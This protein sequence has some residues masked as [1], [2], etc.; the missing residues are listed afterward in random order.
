MNFDPL[1][2]AI[3]KHGDSG[4]VRDVVSYLIGRAVCTAG[5]VWQTLTDVAVATFTAVSTSLREL[6]IDVTPV[7]SGSGDPSPSNPRAI[8]GWTGAQIVVSPTLD[9]QDGTTYDV[10]GQ[11]EAGTVYGGTLTDNGDGTWTLTVTKV[12]RQVASSDSNIFSGGLANVPR[13]FDDL[14]INNPICSHFSFEPGTSSDNTFY[15]VSTNRNLQIRSSAFTSKAEF[16][17]FLEANNVQIVSGVPS[18]VT[19]QT[20]TLTAESVRALL[21][22]NNIFADTGNINTITFRTH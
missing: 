21:G 12:M 5:E 6:V 17:A 8:S 19:P 1:S 3:G 4:P 22:N 2:F 14:S 13:F 15:G 9:A 20:Y 18:S 11:T 16:N 7:Q 10:S